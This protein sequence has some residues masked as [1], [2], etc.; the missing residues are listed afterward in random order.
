M[1]TYKVQWVQYHR[2]VV[3]AKNEE[4][5]LLIGQTLHGAHTLAGIGNVFVEKGK[6]GEVYGE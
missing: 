6:G 1:K 5:A 4:D 2:A 3:K